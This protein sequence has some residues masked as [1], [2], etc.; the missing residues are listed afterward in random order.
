MN[1]QELEQII[2]VAEERRISYAAEKLFVSQPALSQAIK[3]V[4]KK[5]GY[6]LFVRTPEGLVLTP[7]GEGFVKIARQIMTL[8]SELS[9]NLKE[10]A[11]YHIG[12][13]TIGLP[14]FWSSGILPAILGKF[15]G[16]Y[17]GVEITIKEA[18]SS[19]LENM[20]LKREID[21]AITM[22]DINSNK[23]SHSVLLCEEMLI[24]VSP[25]N[26]IAGRGIFVE[27]LAYPTVSPELL[28]GQTFILSYTNQWI[29]QFA[30]DF[31]AVNNFE[32]KGLMFVNSIET[33]KQLTLR[34]LGISFVPMSYVWYDPP[35][36][37]LVYFC[38]K[39]NSLPKWTLRTASL[40]AN[41]DNKMISTFVRLLSDH[42]KCAPDAEQAF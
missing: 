7:E 23:V 2:C 11:N 12:R 42:I 28:K 18:V 30:D 22:L 17:P 6:A 24:A 10:V 32:P 31:F 35:N 29:R 20:L 1:F 15:C 40:K 34:N 36:E 38:I 16:L 3:R 13:L 5:T 8:K 21:V 9:A 27:G 37:R 33:I 41:M 4:E 39:D 26:K 14:A 19:Q 25:K